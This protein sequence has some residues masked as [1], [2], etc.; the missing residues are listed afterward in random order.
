M[1][2][3][4]KKRHA[5]EVQLG[6]EA[7]SIEGGLL[8]PEWLSRIAQLSAGAQSESD[9]RIPK[10]LNL[11][12]E[13]GRYW[14]I[15][16]AHWK[17]FS[18][19]RAGN[20]DGHVLATRFIES[21][22]RD[23]FGFSSLMK[24][25]PV[26]I[27]E[28]DYPIGMS[29]LAGRVPVVVGSSTSGIDELAADFGDG[30]RRRSAFG[31]AQEY[32]NAQDG[33]LWGVV[34]DGILLRVVR[35][36]AR[37]TR[38]AWIE[39]DLQCIFTEERYADFA[40]LWLLVHETRFGRADQPV[41]ECALEIWRS[42]GREEGT[43]ARE[44]LRRGVEDALLALGQ[45]FLSH[46]HNQALRADLRSGSLSPKEYFNQ[47]LRLVYRFIFLLTV[48]ERA[49]LHAS[50]AKEEEKLLYASGYSLRRLRARSVK[51]SAHDRFSDLWEGAKVVLKGVA[52][53][54]PLLG[55]PALAGIFAGN[56]CPHLDAAKLENRALLLAV[57]KLAWLREDESLVR[58]NWRDMGPE[59]LGSV[60]E[61]LLELVPQIASDGRGF[62]FAMGT[63][64]KGNARK[65][66]GSYYTPDSLVQVLLDSALE[67]VVA[68]TISR[69]PDKAA[70][71][72]LGLSIV[73]PAC[74]SG[75]FLLAAARRLASHVARIQADGTPSAADYR[76]A[77]RQV[78]GQC[79]YGVDLNPMAVELCK[80]SLWMEAVEPGLPLTFL[81]SHIQHGN[82]LLGT[83]PELMARGIP[84]AAWEPIEEDDKKVASLLKKRNKAEAGGQR[85]LGF[86]TDHTADENRA[87]GAAV[88]ELEAAS[89]AD[90]AGLEKKETKWDHILD[91]AEYR[92]QKFVAD[93]WC[94]AFVWP[95]QPGETA[96]SAP[97]NELWRQLRDGV[98]Q[99]PALTTKIVNELVDQ[100][101]FFHWHLKFPQMFVKGGFDV[102]L[103]NPPWEHV[104]L[105]EEEWFAERRPDIAAAPNAAVRKRRIA[106]LADE[107]ANLY[108]EFRSALRGFDGETHLMRSSARF[109]LCAKGRINTYAIFAEH[110]R[111]L[112]RQHGRAG[113]IVPAGLVTDDTTKEF[114]ADLV[115]SESLASV[116]HF[117]NEEKLFP[118]VHHA[119][120][121]ILMTIGKTK[122]AD[123][124]FYL[125]QV[126]SLADSERHFSLTSADFETL[127]PNTRT[128]PTFRSHIDA[129]INLAMYRRAGVL[130][131]E[132]AGEFGNPWGVRFMQGIFNMASDSGAFKTR[133]ELEA[134]G[135]TLVGNCF[136]IES[137]QYLPLMEAKML[138][139]FDHRFGTYED[140]TEAQEN[141]GKLPELDDDDHLDPWRMTLSKYW[142]ERTEVGD[143]LNPHWQRGWVLGWRRI[144]GTEKRRTMVTTLFPLAGV[145]DSEFLLLSTESPM[146]QACL[147]G[148]LCSL[149]LDYAARQKVGG[150]NA[151]FHFVRQFPI[152]KPKIYEDEAPW[153]RGVRLQDWFLPRIV[154]L[155]YTA[156]D[157]EPF[158][159]DAGCDGP[160]FRWDTERRFLLRCELDAAFFH[161]YGL[162]RDDAGYVMDTFPIV[163][164][165]DE[166]AHH[167]YRTKRVILE[168]YDAMAEAERTGIPYQTLLD[169]PPADPRVAHPPR[170]AEVI[171]FPARTPPR[172]ELPAWGDALV[173]E[174]AAL[175]EVRLHAGAWA[176]NLKGEDLGM[177]AL[178]AVLRNIS[179]SSTRD[180]VERAVVLAVLP[181]LM[182]PHL[183]AAGGRQWR[184]VI[185]SN[186]LAVDSV[187]GFGIPW[188]TVLRKAI[189]QGVLLENESGHWSAG[190]D[191]ADAPD[192]VLNARAIVVLSWL[193]TAPA[194][195]TE[196]SKQVVAL[197]AA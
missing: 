36:N 110:N 66:T 135:G 42:A 104:E 101:R 134:A 28:R 143:R 67:P 151:S 106:K 136:V 126:S 152:L 41:T 117:E 35:D 182:Q 75:H 86:S 77:L 59:E 172:R 40:A 20:A 91:S 114:F 108:A 97:T 81:N 192:P 181:R 153:I 130:W 122:S 56:Q 30:G 196:V 4:R 51:R 57:F 44:H 178:A 69:N 58:V 10:G 145:G 171:P 188:K 94:A 175:A 9:Y 84:D 8:S 164:K 148:N 72:L 160:P 186:N 118:G 80:V 190:P 23:A 47:L 71:A 82:A 116:Y 195:S 183:T 74:G 155:T 93:A 142:V 105:K 3:A 68:D 141:Q 147:Y 179:R 73:D 167:E 11:R 5:R 25:A 177:A 60:Y 32:L 38:P 29:A 98:G 103:G 88:L 37:L 163:R 19:G 43:R 184:A 150:T 169:P 95:K 133:S 65:T 193:A 14:R 63:D 140:Q 99:P 174:A 187:G 144:T 170:I 125:R 18:A 26:L 132:T 45:G 102:V 128:C 120:R 123:L 100:Y 121:F 7:I 194:E 12:D 173:A 109:P 180:D 138:H 76:R 189:Q 16:Q 165:S 53:G 33:A 191:I 113:F 90:I 146:R 85:T 161:L 119:Y 34:S 22:M 115:R 154:E 197:R 89:D 49:L 15:A 70:D 83:M 39:A 137:G 168:I 156:W 54:E 17:E 111:N 52:S 96:D 46:P 112:L 162:S 48:E 124:V 31:L 139:Q 92:H 185:G 6:F 2:A 62:A 158:A 27:A 1:A 166:K 24:N 157:L 55:L 87:I 107:D 79:I 129:A 64:T 21:L 13:I 127:N 78:V 149:S 159:L 61:S 176:T 50:D 131:R